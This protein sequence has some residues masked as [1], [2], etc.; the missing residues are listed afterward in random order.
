MSALLAE[1]GGSHL[2]PG[3]LEPLYRVLSPVQ[4]GGQAQSCVPF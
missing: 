2:C 3:G 1:G 4:R